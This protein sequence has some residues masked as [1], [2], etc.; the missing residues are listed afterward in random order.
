MF[1]NRKAFPCTQCGKCCQ[2]AGSIPETAGMDRGD[3][4]CRHFDE[5][6]RQCAIY[7]SRPDICRVDRQYEMNYHHTMSW[8]E[9]S[10]LNEMACKILQGMP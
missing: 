8:E 1:D 5:K 6:N 2:H 7:G 9:F 4:T 3:G 10:F